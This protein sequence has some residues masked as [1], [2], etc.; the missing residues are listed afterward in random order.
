MI[1]VLGNHIIKRLG[2]DLDNLD[3]VLSVFE[4]ISAKRNEQVLQQG[5][6]CN[7]VYFIAKGCLQV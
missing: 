6:I 5:E 3:K 7:Y 1:D 4:Y 2:N